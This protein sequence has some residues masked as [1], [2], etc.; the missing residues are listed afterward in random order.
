[1]HAD[2]QCGE[3]SIWRFLERFRDAGDYLM[4]FNGY[5]KN[6]L[7]DRDTVAKLAE[8]KKPRVIAAELGISY[9]TLRN[10]LTRAEQRACSAHSSG[11]RRAV[12]TLT[13]T[14]AAPC[15]D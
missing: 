1:M 5:R 12:F 9:Q 14:P 10:R 11:V 6:V 3:P 15:A 4:A 2:H 13:R 8:G 7:I